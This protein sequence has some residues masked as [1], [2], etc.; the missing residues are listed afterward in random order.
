MIPAPSTPRELRQHRQYIRRP[1]SHR[2]QWRL[3]SL[4]PHKHL[5]PISSQKVAL[6]SYSINEKPRTSRI[7]RA[8]P[9]KLTKKSLFKYPSVNAQNPNKW[10]RF[11]PYR[12]RTRSKCYTW[13]APLRFAVVRHALYHELYL[14]SRRRNRRA[15]EAEL[16]CS[17]TY[18][19][20]RRFRTPYKPNKTDVVPGWDFIH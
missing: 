8:N 17:L 12:P 3:S 13:A 19:K 6:S 1:I 10:R 9:T 11:E 14:Y 4:R 16:S 15:V 5:R 20:C 7:M 18:S 2:S